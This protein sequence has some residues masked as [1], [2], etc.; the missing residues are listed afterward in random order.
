MLPSN[1]QEWLL[2]VLGVAAGYY[3]VGHMKM[4]GKTAPGGPALPGQN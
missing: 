3:I 4:T 1:G 2:L